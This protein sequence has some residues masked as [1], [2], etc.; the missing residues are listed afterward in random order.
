MATI[1]KDATIDVP[2]EV[3]WNALRDVG[4][5][6]RRLAAGFVTDCRMEGNEARI[7]TFANGMQVRELIIAIDEPRRRL[8]WS[9]VGGRLAHHNASAQVLAEGPGRCRFVWICDLLPHEMAPAIEAMIEQG[10]AA[11]VRTLGAK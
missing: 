1:Q 8:V 10:L 7:V 4:A 3:A 6:H 5:V 11:I 2:V 9:A